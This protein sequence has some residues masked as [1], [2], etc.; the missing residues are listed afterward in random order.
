MSYIYVVCKFEF[1][2]SD[3]VYL[4]KAFKDEEDAL[5]FM[6]DSEEDYFLRIVLYD[7]GE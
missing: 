3:D 4:V 6:D 7:D 1:E 5:K 2:D